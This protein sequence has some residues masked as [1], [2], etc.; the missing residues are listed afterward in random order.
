M[1]DP[2]WYGA[3]TVQYGRLYGHILGYIECIH[4]YVYIRAIPLSTLDATDLLKALYTYGA[5]VGN[6]TMRLPDH[7]LPRQQHIAVLSSRG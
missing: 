7:V 6:P 2:S 5:K 1:K 4:G 3:C